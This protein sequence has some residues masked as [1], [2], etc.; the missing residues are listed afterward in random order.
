MNNAF[1]NLFQQQV[2]QD[3]HFDALRISIALRRKRS[4]SGLTAK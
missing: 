4:V 3:N 1:L 2:Q